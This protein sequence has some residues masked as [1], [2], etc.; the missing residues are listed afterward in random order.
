MIRIILVVNIIAVHSG[1]SSGVNVPLLPPNETIPAVLVF[2][3]SVVDT[4]NNNYVQSMFPV[5]CD[6]PP[7]G[8]DFNGGKPTG[9]YSNGRV[10]S[11]MLAEILNVKKLLP[12]YLD[13]NL[14][15][16]DLITGVTFASGAGGYDPLTSKLV[17]VLSLSDQLKL[18]KEYKA[19][20]RAAVG[21]TKTESIVSKSVYILCTGSDDI[22]NTYFSTPFRRPHYDI[23]AYTDLM[24]RSGTTF[25][26]WGYGLAERK[27][28]V[29][30]ILT[31]ESYG[32]SL[33]KLRYCPGALWRGSKKDRSAKSTTNWVFAITKNTERWP[34]ER[35]FGTSQPS[36]T[37]LQLQALLQTGFPESDFA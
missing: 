16:Q 13:P 9:R 32:S 12:P 2:G 6:F 37:P 21:E 26:Q 31:C 14:K 8:K 36:S 7:Y 4:G 27:L 33:G 28:T 25:L 5:R 11:D 22:A 1:G 20:L 35:V 17:S 3:D 30:I 24:L 18:F 29:S 34:S 10:P 19:K 15:L 23:P